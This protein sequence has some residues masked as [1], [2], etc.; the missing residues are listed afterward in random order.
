[1]G[2]RIYFQLEPR[3]IKMFTVT[4]KDDDG[5]PLLSNTCIIANFSHRQ[6]MNSATRFGEISPLWQK[7]VFGDFLKVYLFLGKFV[8]LLWQIFYAIGQKFIVAMSQIL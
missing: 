1:M 4:L 7:K 8:N 3:G 6:G 2:T 5:G